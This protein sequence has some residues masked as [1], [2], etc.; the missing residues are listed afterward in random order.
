MKTCNKCKLE[1]PIFEF[2]KNS[3]SKDGFRH[4]CRECQKKMSVNYS[5][6]KGDE[7]KEKKKLWKLNNHDKV[8]ES[9][10]KS[11]KK[12]GKQISKSKYEKYKKNPIDYLKLLMRSRIRKIVKLMSIE[13]HKTSMEIVGCTPIILKEHL[14]KQFTT[15]MSW[16]NQGKWHID[17]KIPL[18]SAK[19]ENDVYKLCHYTNLQPLWAIDN[20]KKG[21][22]LPF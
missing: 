7:L 8:I 19:N 16:D 10:K 21:S 18:S 9:R 1:K 15:G 4:Y 20:L 14:E 11:Y 2:N 3:S 12:H 17:H 5:Q 22:K 13:K 6:K